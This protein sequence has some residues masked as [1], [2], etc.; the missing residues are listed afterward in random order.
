M[1]I[2]GAV[3]V[4][5]VVALLCLFAAVPT[6]RAA[7]R[8]G[9]RVET[10]SGAAISQVRA[11]AQDEAGFIWVGSLSGLYR[12]DGQRL[13]PQAAGELEGGVTRVVVAE[14]GRVFAL[15][16]RDRLYE[17]DGSAREVVGPDGSALRDVY[18]FT[19]TPEGALW[20]TADRTLWRRGP[21]GVWSTPAGVPPRRGP[22]V[23]AVADPTSIYYATAG[24]VRRVGVDAHRPIV[25]GLV[26]IVDVAP[27]PT[28]ELG[29]VT[30]SDGIHIYAD[31]ELR[32]VMRVDDRGI[33]AVWR[34]GTLWVSHA[35]TLTSI[36][37][38]GRMIVTPAHEGLPGGGPLL[39]D[40]D[41]TLWLGTY[42]DLLTF[43]EPET[44]TWTARDGLHSEHL[45]FL[46]D[47]EGDVWVS[48]WAGQ[49]FIDADAAEQRW[50]EAVL[51]GP[52]WGTGVCT[53]A[54]G[55]LWSTM[56]GGVM[57]RRGGLARAHRFADF[58]PGARC[59]RAPDGDVW[60]ASST[61][62]VVAGSDGPRLLG[63]F[64]VDGVPRVDGTPGFWG[65]Q[66]WMGWGDKVCHAPWMEVLRG[67]AP[68]WACSD[69]P[70]ALNIR[71]FAR[72]DLGELW[73]ATEHAGIWRWRDDDWEPLPAT[74][75]DS[76]DVAFLRPSPRG[77]LWAVGDG[78]A[79]RVTDEGADERG[80]RVLEEVTPAMGLPTLVLGDVLERDDGSLWFATTR[81]V[82]A[83]PAAARARR[84]VAPPVALT[85]ARVGGEAVVTAE[86]L[87]LPYGGNEIELRYAA[88]TYRRQPTLRFRF[89]LGPDRA[90]RDASPAGN[91][92]AF[93]L[94][95]FE[96]PPGHYSVRVQATVDGETWS[97]A[98]DPVA[99][100]VLTP[101]FLRPWAWAL[102][103]LVLTSLAYLGYRL[104]LAA[105]LKTERERARIARDLHDEMGAAL[106]RINVL[107]GLAER[108]SLSEAQRAELAGKIST[109]A[110]ELGSGLRDI[111]WSLRQGEVTLGGLADQLV[112]R[113]AE[114]FG[115]RGARFRSE[116]H[117]EAAVRAHRLPTS[118]ARNVYRIA[119]E[120]MHN[121]A[122]HARAKQ[123]R[124]GFR[125]AG[126]HLR[127]AVEDDG[128]GLGDPSPRGGVGLSSMTERAAECGATVAFI[129]LDP[130]TRVS[131]ELDLDRPGG[132]R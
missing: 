36:D 58:D 118:V 40:R 125:A 20:V 57:E 31:G 51:E 105:V 59:A 35:R 69:I 14:G 91:G 37:A 98:S 124:L 68:P 111:V 6:A 104:R 10:A 66:V 117:L 106:G 116:V 21:A 97:E 63:P 95:L 13:V 130:G 109:T 74:A 7:H 49:G 61:G 128:V 3:L 85:E 87:E 115:G 52:A 33:A 22:A 64:E 34:D 54:D 41:Q 100:E 78:F 88:L 93:D 80:W 112:E 4:R 62:I 89:Q 120:A 122:T 43:P 44:V 2:L 79:L 70:G 8:L 114:L 121:A 15:T 83:V 72:T 11:I 96:L 19:V 103:L 27:S 42:T 18:G 94:H 67:E 9:E 55:T 77:G 30:M 1:A 71:A 75:G 119:L 46:A 38:K 47:F 82:V 45:R 101:W 53:S 90:W 48:S 32:E 92:R 12:W 39:V 81:G 17:V 123:V 113:G 126:S 129:A 5:L 29:I 132:E 73:V 25:E 23:F 24:E 84:P 76:R 16:T 56:R 107:A 60:L 50:H 86:A 110:H 65:E 127:V 26:G 28:G 102:G 131:L 99:F 108:G